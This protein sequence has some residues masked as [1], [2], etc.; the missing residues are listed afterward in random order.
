MAR[1]ILLFVALALLLV[2]VQSTASGRIDLSRVPTWSLRE[3]AQP[4]RFVYAMPHKTQKSQSGS[5]AEWKKAEVAMAKPLAQARIR[6][7]G[8]LV[9]VQ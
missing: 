6:A 1:A 3:R 2:G 9:T 8:E 7:A 5:T 4:T